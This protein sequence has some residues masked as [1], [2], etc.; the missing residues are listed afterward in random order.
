M[1]DL[2]LVDQRA[3][4]GQA[5]LQ[6]AG[7]RVDLVVRAV[8]ELHELQQGG[9]P[10]P[11]E[12]PRQAEIPAVDEQVLPHG[13]LDVEGVLLRHHAQPGPDR[14]AFLDRI[15]AEDGQLPAGGRRDAADHPHRG[16]LA[17]AVRP[18]EPERLP[19]VQVE[20]DAVDRSEAAELLGQ[21]AGLDEHLGFGKFQHLIQASRGL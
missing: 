20:V 9:G 2:R 4:D 19:A 5:A 16:G 21:A 1:Q 3:G 13:Q 6:A 8:R 17:R 15:A 11:D 12:A 14:R 7:Q 10:L 18:E